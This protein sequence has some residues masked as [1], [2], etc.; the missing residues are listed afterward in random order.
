[1]KSL[2]GQAE[3]LKGRDTLP[4]GR[5]ASCHDFAAIPPRADEPIVGAAVLDM[6]PELVRQLGGDPECLMSR[7][8]IDPAATYHS[9]SVLIHK[10]VAHLLRD[11]AEDLA[12]PEFGLR[13]AAM[14]DCHKVLGPMGVAMKNSS[15]VGEA[16]AYCAQNIHTYSLAMRSYLEPE[17]P[18]RS[19]LRVEV[20]LR[21]KID[22]R[23]IIE[24]ALLLASHGIID[25]SDGA[26]QVREVWFKHA[27]QF[28]PSTYRDFFG[29]E[30][31]FGQR[32][33]GVVLTDDDLRS[34]VVDADGML[35]KMAV[36]FIELRYPPAQPPIQMCVR[37]LI[38]QRLADPDCTNDRIAAS[39]CVRPRT[40]Q[41]RLRAE[42]TSFDEM[43]DTVR[44]EVAI[45]YITRTDMPL[46]QVA[47]KVGY[48]ESSV[49]SRSCYRWFSA[50]PRQ[51]RRQMRGD[52]SRH[53]D[54]VVH[55]P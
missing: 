18:Q 20:L 33:N 30:I 1:M 46:L 42:G 39:L 6:F 28:S 13:L 27:A 22:V 34:Q 7:A 17:L 49:L 12:C 32:A 15:T 38:E 3:R 40:L 51:L 35:Y 50:S 41:R 21:D 45:H 14:Q 55:P 2:I 9:D 8:R 53:D 43:K 5:Q 24:H 23:Q 36:S 52:R 29:C 54:G 31:R 4:T 44:R 11:A 26:A 19:L 37:T 47:E 25:I 10:T 48:A 16:I